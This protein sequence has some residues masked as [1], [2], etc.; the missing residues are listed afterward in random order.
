M[1]FLFEIF[2]PDYRA[3]LLIIFNL[4]LIESLLS[5]DNAAVLATMVMDLPPHQRGKALRYGILGAYFFRGLSLVFV[6][7]LLQLIFL[8]LLGGLYLLWLAYKYFYTKATPKTQ[9]DLLNKRENRIY[10]ATIGKLGVFWSTVVLIE[11]MDLS[12]S[13]DNVFAAV[14]FTNNIYLICMGVFIGILAM[15]FAAQGF[16]KLMSRFPFL[17]SLA[18]IVISLLGLK[19]V[20]SYACE[21]FK[22]ER[23][24]MF[25]NGHH[26]DLLFSV[27]TASVFILPVLTSLAFNF[28]KRAFSSRHA[29]AKVFEP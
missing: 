2:G 22:D 7:V 23:F 21:F 6:S 29:E 5:V 26:A 15:R 4:I 3:S 20:S 10:K 25:L 24:C 27:L 19:L 18:F 11:F 28:P 9:D 8:K 13:I 16:V 17:E 12:F 1:D 14:A